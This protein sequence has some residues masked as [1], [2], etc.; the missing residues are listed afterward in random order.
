MTKL[1]RLWTSSSISFPTKYRLYKS[2]V[3][4]IL[5]YGCE[6]LTPHADIERMILAYEHNFFASLY[7]AQE[8]RVRLE[9]DCITF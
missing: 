6:I 8:Q 9:H 1:S 5:L 3:V 7:V 2:L 4:S